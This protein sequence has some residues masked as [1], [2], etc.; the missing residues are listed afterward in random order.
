MRA[1]AAA[2][3]VVLWAVVAV[4]GARTQDPVAADAA[5]A[6]TVDG[7]LQAARH[8]WLRWPDLTDVA[9]ALRELYAAEPDRLIWFAGG[10][11]EPALPGAI[12]S[13]AMSIGRVSSRRAAAIRCSEGAQAA[14]MLG[15]T[16]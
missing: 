16:R 9:P 13:L 14:L 10:R 12:E 11:A 4:P 2:A 3:A 7:V 5:V 1:V 6:R 15:C 8:P